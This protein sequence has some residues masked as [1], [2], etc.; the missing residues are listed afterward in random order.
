MGMNSLF[1]SYLVVLPILIP[2]TGAM[3]ALLLRRQP[4]VQAGWAL[5]TMVTSLAASTWLLLVVARSG[6]AQVLQSGGWAAPFGI[7][8]VGDMLAAVFVVMTQLVMVCGLWYAIGSKD[9]VVTYPTFFTLFLTLATGLTGAFLTGDLFNMYV[10]AELLVISGTVLTA[11]SDDRFGTEAAQKYFYISLLA[12]FFMLLSVGSLYAGYG[13]LNMADL[14]VRIGADGTQLLLWPAIAFLFAT[15]MI[16]SAVF[17]FHFW[18]PDFHTAAPTAVSAMLSSVVVKLGVYGFLRMTTLLFVAQSGPLRA[19]LLVL[20]VIGVIFGGLSAI[21]TH[22][23][24]RMLAY[25]TLAQVGFILVAIAWGTPLALGTAVVFS[26]NHSVIKAAMLMLAGYVASHASVKSASFAVVTGVGRR[27]PLAGAFFFVGSL[28]LA[29]IP[30]TNGFVS[31]MMLFSSGLGAQGYWAL[32]TIGL[33]S[34]FTLLYTMRAFQRIWWMQPG[35]GITTKASGD[36][37]WAPGL[38]MVLIV[39]LGVWAEPLVQVAMQTST[40]LGD[41]QLYIRAVLGG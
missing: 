8:L 37:L 28:A 14:S 33:A 25:S 39:L 16:K 26:F 6:Q 11:V 41:P 1:D 10:F 40:W 27:L 24:K 38:L 34:L 18:Q 20:G 7:T 31:K 3:V 9:K 13:T 19:I 22:N 15:F 2:L 23:V 5:G 35:G 36:V 30:P 29:G 17:P 4:R 21:G 12:S 32:L